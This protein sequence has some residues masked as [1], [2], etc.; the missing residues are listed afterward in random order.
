[1]NLRRAGLMLGVVVALGFA[2]W[3]FPGQLPASSAPASSAASSAVVGSTAVDSLSASAQS[4]LDQVL[5][6]HHSV[7]TASA[8]YSQ[9]TTKL[10]T[11]YNPKGVA[12]LNQ[13]GVSSPGYTASVTSNGV[14]QSVT[15]SSSAGGQIQQLSVAVVVDSSLRPAPALATIRRTVSAAMGLQVSRGDKITVVALP[16]AAVVAASTPPLSLASRVSPYL[17]SGLAVAATTTLLL[18]LLLPRRRRQSLA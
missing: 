11:T 9:P 6:P 16:M 2:I 1:M 13:S 5:G 8:T 7:I 17:P 10:A 14:S 3:Q 15:R 4:T 12:V 18:F